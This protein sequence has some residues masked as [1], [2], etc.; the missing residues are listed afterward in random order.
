MSSRVEKASATALEA[1]TS[2]RLV[3]AWTARLTPSVGKEL[4]ALC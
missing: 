2:G 4:V 1:F 3:F